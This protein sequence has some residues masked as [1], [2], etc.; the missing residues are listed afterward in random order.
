L[1]LYVGL[2][3]FPWQKQ[4]STRRRLLT[5]KLVLNLR[6][7][8]VECYTWIIALHVLKFGHF[9]VEQKFLESF[10]LWCGRWTQKIR[11]TDHVRNEV[12]QVHR[13]QEKRNIL[14]AIK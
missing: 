14:H 5:S 10:D 3:G 7:K 12:L 2:S 4:H 8:L 6:E 13:V 11:W 9:G 1:N